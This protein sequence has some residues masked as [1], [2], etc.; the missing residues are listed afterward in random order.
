MEMNKNT[1]KTEKEKV[2]KGSKTMN[3]TEKTIFK[4]EQRGS[5]FVDANGIIKGMWGGFHELKEK[6][7]NGETMY[8]LYH[9]TSVS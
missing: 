8:E 5:Y 9:D 3:T 4:M 6:G 2:R 1:D 7:P